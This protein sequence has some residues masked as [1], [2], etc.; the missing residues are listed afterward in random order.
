MIYYRHLSAV[1]TAPYL[2]QTLGIRHG[3]GTSLFLGKSRTYCEVCLDGAPP[4]AVLVSPLSI[5]AWEDFL[6]D[7]VEGHGF[8]PPL[9][10]L[11]RILQAGAEFS[12]ELREFWSKPLVVEAYVESASGD[13]KYAVAID[14]DGVVLFG[15]CEK[16]K[17][18]GGAKQD[19][20]ASH[21]PPGRFL[22]PDFGRSRR[23]LAAS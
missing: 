17:L 3:H 12:A 15:N 1:P 21:E 23:H 13:E 19:D 16:T 8:R 7:D 4:R 18:F 9:Q 5:D 2:K 20:N 11:Q 14:Q 10:E 6:S 22:V